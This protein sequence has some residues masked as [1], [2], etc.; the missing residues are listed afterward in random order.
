VKEDG[1]IMNT[2]RPGGREPSG[3]TEAGRT[4]AG[5]RPAAAGRT[6]AGRRLAAWA[7]TS[8][9]VGGGL[10]GAGLL[11][12]GPAAMADTG[13]DCPAATV[14]G[15]TATV[16]C[17]YTGGS[18]YWTV[19]A[20][21][22]Q[23]TVTLYGATGGAEQVFGGLGA[24]V[25][26]TV[27]VTG[28]TTLQVNVGQA[29]HLNGGGTFGGG[30]TG[31]SNG[32]SGGGESDVRAPG[33]NGDYPMSAALLVAGGGG[34]GGGYGFPASGGALNG[35]GGGNADSPGGAGQ[36]TTDTCGNQLGAP[37]GGGAGTTAG[38]GAGGASNT[39]TD[40]QA[41]CSP[42]SGGDGAGGS[43]GT[44][45]NASFDSNGGGGG[46]GG[47]YYGGGAGGGGGSDG[48]QLPDASGAGGG[49]GASYTGS[50]GASVTEGVMPPDQALNG[51]VTITYSTVTAIPVTVT[52]SQAYGSASPQFAAN[53]TAPSGATVSGSVTC[54]TVNGGTAIA[55]GLDAS[56]SYT[57]DGSS[58]SGLSVPSGYSIAYTGG[59]FTVTP[60]SQA[61]S[62]TAPGTGTVG[63]SA[64][65]TATG[66]ASGNPVT[67]SV[68]P[69]SGT[70]VCAVSG[71]TVSYTGAGSCV[72]DA[73]QAGDADYAAA[74]PVQATI[75]VT[76]PTVAPAFTADAPPLHAGVGTTYSY[77]FAA[78]GTPA[79]SFSLGAGAP[80]WLS[81]GSATGVVT[82]TPPKGTTS[83]AYSVTA[84]NA[85]GSVTAGPFTVAVSAKADVTAGLTC[86]ASLTV[87]ASGT[88]TL[89][90]TNNGPALATTTVAGATVPAGLTVTGCSAGCSRLGGLLGW[91]LGSL[92]AGQSDVLTVNITAARA[93]TA[94]VAAA[95]GALTPDPDLLNNLAAATVKITR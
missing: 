43:S 47:G 79:A 72:I 56:G 66:G 13:P 62:F 53:F 21:V 77:Q 10:A 80:S 33:A 32:S 82:G 23:A 1:E 8:L 95:D 7:A 73:S 84:T 90:V 70:G 28:G 94:V 55:A 87:G 29:G 30:G 4:R 50:T 38:G 63:Q 68:D 58:C 74:P 12:G 40:S 14:S 36:G 81:V 91:S 6:N 16:T 67:F 71:A 24:E 27:P 34:G 65:L 92:P 26:G 85:A 31:G 37:A 69:S 42:T 75:A 88:C 39:A 78:S 44:G 41:A 51:E 86:P 17:A 49:G 59:A 19:P 60:A 57:I 64:T 93:G 18:Q 11:A 89:T 61:V 2:I 35:G 45:G 15:T 46:G 25:S 54:A 3:R 22:T 48:G 20:N 5:W 52:G 9:L 76:Q 83:F